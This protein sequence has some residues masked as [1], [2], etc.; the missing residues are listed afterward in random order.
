[1]IIGYKLSPSTSVA[2]LDVNCPP[3]TS[4]APIR[5][6]LHLP[7]SIAPADVIVDASA[8]TALAIARLEDPMP[9]SGKFCNIA[10]KA[11]SVTHLNPASSANL[12]LFELA[13]SITCPAAMQYARR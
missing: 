2:P 5:R 9:S 6:Q 1:M 10:D 7:T 11:E 4:I 3:P 8:L 13:P 12:L